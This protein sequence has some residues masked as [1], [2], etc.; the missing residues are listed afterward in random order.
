MTDDDGLLRELQEDIGRE[1]LER[2]WKVWGKWIIGG[3]A[4]F[5]LGTAANV[6]WERYTT[7][8]N[9]ETGDAF[10]KAVE[11]ADAGNYTEAAKLYEPL[12]GSGGFGYAAL[13]RL[14]RAEALTQTG[15]ISGAMA[16]YDAMA[17]NTA[18]DPFLRAVAELMLTHLRL[19]QEDKIAAPI[20]ITESH[21]L[22]ASLLEYRALAQLTEGEETAA[23]E[24][25]RM[26]KERLQTPESL[27]QRAE[28]ISGT[29][30]VEPAG[31]QAEEETQ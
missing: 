28:E 16:E 3:I 17:K 7:S 4:A 10:Q 13:A 23:A 20:E 11:R 5:I 29:L 12:Y 24:S 2:F 30:D 22:Y 14:K 26:L 9:A 31:I 27:R 25:L 18:F 1:R 6:G 19:K 15:E 21:P 8:R